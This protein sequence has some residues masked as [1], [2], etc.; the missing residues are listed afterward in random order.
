M[1]FYCCGCQNANWKTKSE[2]FEK[3]VKAIANST[4]KD[5]LKTINNSNLGVTQAKEVLKE[6]KIEHI[7]AK[8]EGNEPLLS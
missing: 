1:S 3:I 6:F 2:G 8:C 7:E 5:S 4:L